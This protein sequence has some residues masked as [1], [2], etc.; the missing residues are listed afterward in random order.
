MKI[1][2]IREVSH[3]NSPSVGI[4]IVPGTIKT[5]R[6]LLYAMLIRKDFP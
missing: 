3:L 6:D 5:E 1:I 4:N 2:V